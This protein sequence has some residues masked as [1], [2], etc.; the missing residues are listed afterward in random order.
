M[1]I[2]SFHRGGGDTA[3]DFLFKDEFVDFPIYII[4]NNQSLIADFVQDTTNQD[5]VGEPP[6]KEVVLQEQILLLQEPM[7]LKRSTR[8][9]RSVVSYN[10]I[11]FLQEYEVDICMMED[12]L[13]NFFNV[14]ESS[15]SQSG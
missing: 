11:V 3:R 7:P 5:N 13:I 2:S 8:E 6:I 10:Y 1:R 9:L 4:G 14:M 15:N 12:D